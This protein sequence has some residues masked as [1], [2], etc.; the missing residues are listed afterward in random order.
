MIRDP[1]VVFDIEGLSVDVLE[2]V[3]VRVPLTEPV[4]VSVPYIVRVCLELNE[5]VLEPV[6]DAVLVDEP[7]TLEERRAVPELVAVAVFVRVGRVER[8]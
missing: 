7:V 3:E 8:E 2:L 6:F 5:D 4:D 1:T